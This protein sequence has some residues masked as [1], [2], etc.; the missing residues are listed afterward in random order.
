MSYYSSTDAPRGGAFL[1]DSNTYRGHSDDLP[2]PDYADVLSIQDRHCLSGLSPPQTRAWTLL[3]IERYRACILA[4]C[5]IHNLA[6]PLHTSLPTEILVYVFTQIRPTSR[7]DIGLAHVC[8]LWRSVLMRTSV[9]WASL[10]EMKIDVSSVSDNTVLSTLLKRSSPRSLSLYV[11]EFPPL[12]YDILHPH[13]S[14][15]THFKARISLDNLPEL[16]EALNTGMP[17]LQ[18]LEIGL[19]QHGAE[20]ARSLREARTTNPDVV[21]QLERANVPCLRTLVIPGFLFTNSSALPSLR[22]LNLSNCSCHFCKCRFSPRLTV[23]L[24]ALEQAANLRSL[25]FQRCLLHNTEFNGE[26]PIVA[27]PHLENFAAW[28]TVF[29]LREVVAVISPPP[30]VSLQL[31]VWPGSDSLSFS[32][33]LRPHAGYRAILS[34]VDAVHIKATCVGSQTSS[35][36]I[37]SYTGSDIRLSINVPGQNAMVRSMVANGVP[38]VEEVISLFGSAPVNKLVV[39]VIDGVPRHTVLGVP[40]WVTLFTAFPGIVTVEAAFRHY[41][42]SSPSLLRQ[43]QATA[44]CVFDGAHWQGLVWPL[45]KA[46]PIAPPMCPSLQRLEITIEEDRMISQFYRI[47]GGVLRIRFEAFGYRLAHL[48]LRVRPERCHAQRI[49]SL[50]ASDSTRTYPEELL[51]P[52]VED[53]QVSMQRSGDSYSRSSTQGE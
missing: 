51:R 39:E 3:R 49:Q 35:F 47:L 19:S 22:S 20:L 29:V 25:T 42:S 23:L 24:R 2:Y 10:L 34:S 6:T 44:D 18:A 9:F 40:D 17:T 45:G 8:R 52:F 15:L 5:S 4:L 11:S 33:W 13:F 16:Y 21:P 14:R 43:T 41:C 38:L 28:E 7:K 32:H 30:T 12:L 1:G 31:R 50:A 53:L 27:L 26:R 48:A 46:N 36:V 37:R